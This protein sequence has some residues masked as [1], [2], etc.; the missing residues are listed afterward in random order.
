MRAK[1]RTSLED[2]FSGEPN[3]QEDKSP[4]PSQHPSEKSTIHRQTVYL[5][6]SVYE[7]LRQLAFDERLK[8]HDYLMQGLD[9]VFQN[10]GLPKYLALA[11]GL[12]SGLVPAHGRGFSVSNR[13]GVFK[14]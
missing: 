3:I 6:H 8:M 10:K 12:L 4:A 9:L 1:K 13:T 14:C 11:R 2:V 7:Q 5:P